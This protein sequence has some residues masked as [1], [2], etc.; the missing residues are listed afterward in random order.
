MVD[1]PISKEAAI[2]EL[3][4]LRDTLGGP[5]AKG[6]LDMALVRLAGF[7][8]MDA[9]PVVHARWVH[10]QRYG[11]SGGWVW[12]CSACRREAISPIISA[13]KYCHSCGA[14]MDG[15]AEG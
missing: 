12:R 15:G 11:D 3:I 7:P 6:V 14:K 5:F 13:L 4:N 9:V 1:Y 2:M 8:Q 10:E